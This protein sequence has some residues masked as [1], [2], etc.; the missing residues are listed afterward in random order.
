MGKHMLLKKRPSSSL[1]LEARSLQ[2]EDFIM[3]EG[4]GTLLSSIIP[5]CKEVTKEDGIGRNEDDETISRMSLTVYN[6]EVN[7]RNRAQRKVVAAE[8]M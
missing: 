5:E 8:Y 6:V 7:R 4:V 2:C 3:C 1:S